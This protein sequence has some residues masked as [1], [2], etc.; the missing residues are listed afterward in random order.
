ML[1]CV[2]V[3]AFGQ[4]A[5]RETLT[6]DTLQGVETVYFAAVEVTKPFHSLTIQA[7]C[8]E[9][10]GTSDGKLQVQ[11]SADGTS[12]VTIDDVGINDWIAM[13]ASDTAKL[14]NSGN[15]FTITDTGVFTV[16]IMPTTPVMPFSHFRLKGIGTTGD[17]TLITMKSLVVK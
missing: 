12:Y 8:T 5:V 2:G 17:T 6:P 3:L 9:L 4:R 16:V 13:F 15:E 11:G 10:G 14:A 7:L 1:A